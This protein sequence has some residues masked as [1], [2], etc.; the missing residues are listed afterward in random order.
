MAGGGRDSTAGLKFMFHQGSRIGVAVSPFSSTGHVRPPSMLQGQTHFLGCGSSW[1]R[2]KPNS[3]TAWPAWS[4]RI[5]PFHF[6][7]NNLGGK[8]KTC[9]SN[10]KATPSEVDVLLPNPKTSLLDLVRKVLRF[11]NYALRA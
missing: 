11:H 1:S 9:R 3:R 4:E 6:V 8:T 7:Q 10:S 5:F 2:G